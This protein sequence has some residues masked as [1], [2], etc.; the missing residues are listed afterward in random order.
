MN[1][2][3]KQIQ[4]FFFLLL[5]LT[6]SITYASQNILIITI[7]T[8]RADRLSCYGNQKYR[9]PHIDRLAERGILFR[10]S[11]ALTPTT[12]P[13]HA[14]I[15]L[16]TSPLE[17][18]VHDNLHS[19]VEQEFLTLAEHLK[20]SGYST[21]AIVG[22]FPLDS[23][24]GLS[25]GFDMYDDSY[26]KV[27]THKFAYGERL[28]EEVVDKAIG[29]LDKQ[30]S[31]WFLWMHCFDPHDPYTPPNPFDELHKNSPYDGEVAYVD[32]ALGK[33]FH[34]L[35]ENG[36]FQNTTVIFTSD[37]G[38]A[39][40]E[41]GE[42]YHGYLAYNEVMWV[43]LI[44]AI[45]GEKHAIVDHN[46][47]H[48]DIFPTVC[49]ILN[50]KKPP[51]LQ[52]TSLLSIKKNKNMPKRTIYF[53]SLFPYLNRG[54]APIR[55][56]IRGNDKFID[57]PIPEFYNLE[58]DFDEVNNLAEQKD[59]GRYKKHLNSIIQEQATSDESK[60]NRKIDRESLKILTS[61]GYISSP[62]LT[63]KRSF[64]PED[65]VKVLLPDSNRAEAAIELHRKGKS[66]EGI[67]ILQD[68]I[69]NEGKIDMAYVYLGEIYQRIGKLSQ[70]L[71][72][73]QKGIERHP[74][75]Y[76]VLT[77]YAHALLSAKRYNEVV[78]IITK[79]VLPRMDSDA[80]IWNCLG[81]AHWKKGDNEQAIGAFEWA[82]SLDREYANVHNNLGA[83]Y[84]SLFL[85]T[86]IQ[87]HLAQ[88]IQFYSRAL[89]LDSHH[90]P[91][92]VGLG[93]AHREEG[94][95]EKAIALWEKAVERET[96][97]ADTVFKLS[98]A[99]LEKGDK[100]KAL[101]LLL[102]SKQKYYRYLNDSE[103]QKLDD[104][105]AKCNSKT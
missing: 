60:G 37:H 51:F 99:Y 26:N 100:A 20:T 3:L 62:Q 61:L 55:G 46:V 40:G 44:L 73:L 6:L 96:Y 72:I 83:V 74:S 85:K 95:L 84:F 49:D 15:F 86:K 2:R 17:H 12:L 92:Y 41:H 45:P 10:K 39:L 88:A 47:S 14:N 68:V 59:L 98:Q 94:N 80:E 104:F 30:K 42:I 89:E 4:I 67:K 93:S 48:L 25:Q 1:N 7:D 65:D 19:I 82:I 27:S 16:G 13:S 87:K 69:K 8:L 52:G 50:I 78:Q 9:T 33:F 18:G 71:D 66:A 79:N 77:H 23:R 90:I 24:F 53:E 35:E 43:P 103:K 38:E 102:K 58:N 28:A 36:I 75:S 29:W 81:V 91:S 34:F 105:I 5:G 64:G 11:F 54:W 56:Y 31:P 97:F 57:S 76:I 101:D 70:A 63:P 22:A 21:G 32:S